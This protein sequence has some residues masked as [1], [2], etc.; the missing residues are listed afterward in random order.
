MYAKENE[1]LLLCV[2]HAREMER[3]VSECRPSS[4]LWSKNVNVEY[5]VEAEKKSKKNAVRAMGKNIQKVS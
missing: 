2:I 3:F 5:V 1:G 4:V